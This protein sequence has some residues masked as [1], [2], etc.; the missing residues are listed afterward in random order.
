MLNIKETQNYGE[1][2]DLF[3]ANGLEIQENEFP[4]DGL[5]KC[6]EAVF[7]EAGERAGAIVLE[8]RDGEFIVGDI[9]V[10]KG[11]RHMDIGT[12]LMGYLLREARGLGAKR[13]M[14]VAKVPDFFANFGF[15]KIPR[16]NSPNISNCLQCHQFGE[17]CFPEVM[18]LYL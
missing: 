14:L 16:E 11:Y 3:L 18:E 5:I 1:L 7:S 13:I 9:A 10:E 8:K 2:A 15:V 12:E 4:P 6:W 17:S